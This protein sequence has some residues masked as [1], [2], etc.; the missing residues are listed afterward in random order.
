MSKAFTKEEV[1]PPERSGRVR[2]ASGLPAGAT[3]YITSGGAT[4]LRQEL[5]RL[6]QSSNDKAERIAEL[7]RILGSVTVVEPPSD[8]DENVG[9]GATVMIRDAT[10]KTIAYRIVG[11]D[12]L[13]LD[14]DAVSWISPLGR[15]LL[16]AKLGDHVTLEDGGAGRIVKIE[17]PQGG[18]RD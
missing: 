5:Q 9:F 10:N 18:R 1:D 2:S 4:Q 3:N 15:S 8:P 7:E 14:V 17:Y 12:E 13:G 16:A 11:V 6:R